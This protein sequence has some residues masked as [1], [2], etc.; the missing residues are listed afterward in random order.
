MIKITHQ[1]DNSIKFTYKNVEYT[2]EYQRGDDALYIQLDDT[3]GLKI[4]Y[5]NTKYES[6]EITYNNLLKF[7]ENNYNFFPTIYDVI[8]DGENILLELEHI[9]NNHLPINLNHDWIPGQD[10]QFLKDNLSTDIDTLTK[11]NY[12]ILQSGLCPEDEWYKKEKNLINNKIIDFHRFTYFPQRYKMPT[13]A[14]SDT[15]SSVYVDALNRYNSMGI[16]KWKGKIY[17]GYRFNNG[18]EFLGYSSDNMEYDSYRK[19]NFMY[20]NKCKGGK[21]LDIGCNEGFL[22]IQAALHG[23]ES[24]YGFDIT[25]QDIALAKD[26]NDRILK[27]DNVKFG[28]EDGVE[29]VNN[30]K[31]SYNM[32]ILSSVLHLIYLNTLNTWHMKP[33]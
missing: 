13:E 14:T 28:V 17:E 20:L 16:N 1:I 30:I 8:M 25:K 12:S 2:R 27:L 10:K 5:P 18:E 9:H 7:K 26:I 4:I 33:L 21:V 19:L 22:S 11:L 15:L 32:I 29:F 3:K 24:V 6:Q 23:A 31:D